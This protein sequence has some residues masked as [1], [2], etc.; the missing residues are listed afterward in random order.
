MKIA[1][2][3]LL[4][5]ALLVATGCTRNAI[6]PAH[7]HYF[8]VRFPVAKVTAGAAYPRTVDPYGIL[9]YIDG[10]EIVRQPQPKRI[11]VVRAR[12]ARSGNIFWYANAIYVLNGDGTHFTRIDR[13]LHAVSIRVPSAYSPLEGAVADARHRDIIAARAST[14]ELAVVD[15]WKWYRER[16]PDGI[17][18]FATT[19]AGGP[20]GK[21]FLVV[22]DQSGAAIVVKNRHTGRSAFVQLPQNAC[23]S[24]GDASLRVPVDVRGRDWYRTWATSGERAA[25]IDL[26]TGRVLR[27][28]ELPGCAMQI[29]ASDPHAAVLLIGVSADRRYSSSLA[30]IDRRGVHLL[31]QYGQIAGL[32]AGAIL[33]RFNR[34]WWFDPSANAFVCRT[35]LS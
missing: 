18:P 7:G 23:F 12:D 24:A 20:H 4:F 29:L 2:R 15:V 1:Y 8:D 34:L 31:T 25:S 17:Q 13:H 3:I 19:L 22:G 9:W 35:P 32:G 10:G 30:R 21:K 6:R 14:R 33:D 26:R 5:L 28:W 27:V 11:E 16:L